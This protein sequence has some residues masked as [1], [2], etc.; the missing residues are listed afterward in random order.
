M[1]F[2]TLQ[3]GMQ[4]LKRE[5]GHHVGIHIPYWLYLQ[6]ASVHISYWLYL[7]LASVHISYN[8]YVTPFVYWVCLFDNYTYSRPI[9]SHS[10]SNLFTVKVKVQVRIYPHAIINRPRVIPYIKY[11]IEVKQGPLILTATT[12]LHVY[13]LLPFYVFKFNML[14]VTM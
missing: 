11:V 13:T 6:L 14:Y 10:H 9:V 1:L 2:L 5:Y 8:I 7:Q 12:H 4:C 3:I